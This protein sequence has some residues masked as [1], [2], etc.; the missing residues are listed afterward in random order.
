MRRFCR[1]DIILLAEENL[2]GNKEEIAFRENI[3]ELD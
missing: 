1:V 3:P 2:V